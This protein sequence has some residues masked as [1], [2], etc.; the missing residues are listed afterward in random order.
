MLAP[1]ILVPE[2]LDRLPHDGYR[3]VFSFA[4]TVDPIQILSKWA[5]VGVVGPRTYVVGARRGS[6]S[7]A[8]VFASTHTSGTSAA[9]PT[10][11]RCD[12]SYVPVPLTG[13]LARDRA[14]ERA[15]HDPPG[16]GA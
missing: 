12:G 7:S 1:K 13:A 3:Y 6:V 2:V 8:P 10:S 4:P 16:L 5:W 11:L 14:D 9:P 15:V